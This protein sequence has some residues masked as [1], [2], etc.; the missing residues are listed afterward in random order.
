MPLPGI[1]R[2]AVRLWRWLPTPL[3]CMRLGR[4]SISVHPSLP[5]SMSPTFFRIA[6][7]KTILKGDLQG[8]KEQ[9]SVHQNSWFPGTWTR[10]K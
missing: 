8:A 5:S 7:V 10:A 1:K 4:G 9:F 6:S 3:D 2:D